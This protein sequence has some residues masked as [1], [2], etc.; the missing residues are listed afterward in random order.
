MVLGSTYSH[1]AR[2]P[3]QDSGF[4]L[5]EL[6]ITLVIAVLLLSF[7]VPGFNE[8]MR[9]NATAAEANN[10]VRDLNMARSEAI[11]RGDQIT[12]RRSGTNWEDGWTV[13]VD[14]DRDGQ[15]DTGDDDELRVHTPSN[16]RFTLRTGTSFSD[17]LAYL[18]SGVATGN[19]GTSGTFRLCRSDGDTAKS[20]SIII[21]NSGRIGLDKGTATC[22]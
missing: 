10:F 14:V 13:F 1:K 12:V 9:I 7:G 21:N 4:T 20:R 19:G 22:P 3:R 11:N 17:W 8:T 15:L 6:V 18:P 5:I 2:F 16:T